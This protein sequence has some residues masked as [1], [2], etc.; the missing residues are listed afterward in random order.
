MRGVAV[1]HYH[2]AQSYNLRSRGAAGALEE[3][4]IAKVSLHWLGSRCHDA[5]EEPNQRIGVLHLVGQILPFE[6]PGV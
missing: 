3:D 4:N 6:V 1:L 5:T 2:P